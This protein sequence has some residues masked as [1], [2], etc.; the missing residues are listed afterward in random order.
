MHI[1]PADFLFAIFS[2]FFCLA[3]LAGMEQMFPDGVCMDSDLQNYTQILAA[4]LHPEAFS[5]DPLCPAYASYPGVPNLFIS[6]AQWLSY[7]GS[8][9]Y[10]IFRA[11]A[12]AV[13]LHLVLFYALGRRLFRS[14]GLS[15]LF[16]LCLSITFYWNFGT[17]WGATH[18]QA[19][20]RVLY[21]GFFYPLWLLLGILAFRRTWLRPL[22]LLCIGLSVQVHTV[23]SMTCAAMFLTAFL[24]T[25]QN[26][27][28]AKSLGNTA[29]CT[30]AFL[31]PALPLVFSHLGSMP[32]SLTAAEL[33]MVNQC[34][35]LM[36]ENDWT[37]PWSTLGQTLLHYSFPAAFLPLGL[38][39][40]CVTLRLKNRLSP[41]GQALLRLLPGF[42]LGI[43]GMLA[44]CFL[45]MRFVG[46]ADF[47]R[48][49][50]EL[51]RGTRFLI[52]LTWMSC[53]LFLACFW[54]KLPSLAR[55]SV[56]FL[57]AILIGCASQDA[58]WLAARHFAAEKMHA[59]FLDSA[60]A[61][62]LTEQSEN[63][64]SALLELMRRSEKDDLVYTDTSELAVRYAAMRPLV[65][66]YKDGWVV[67][68]ARDMR[69]IRPWLA[70]QQ[71]RTA[72]RDASAAR[73][74]DPENGGW[75]GFGRVGMPFDAAQAQISLKS[76]RS[77]NADWLLLHNSPETKKA[78]EGHI[79]YE[80]PDW[81]LAG[82]P[83]TSRYGQGHDLPV[84]GITGTK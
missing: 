83:H 17:F 39:L 57:A 65:P 72:A 78:L 13:F 82:Q 55:R 84:S 9:A 60:E 19:V 22:L 31:L 5:A 37:A 68:Y 61:V 18:S 8:A 53:F 64:R 16:S 51:F 11:G 59:P 74:A 43:A 71:A 75:S 14:A 29:L 30:A 15:A 49:S 47:G 40:W 62:R 27:S 54:E 12:L 35:A 4:W 3:A 7:D 6:L 56:P 24:V 34:W 38:A 70:E 20:P 77:W 44:M 58:Q 52:P 28:L 42:F 79:C 25:P 45:E 26:R 10:G 46:R 76:A 32:N 67:Y 50:L 48:V 66:T 41:E 21:A 36:A 2:A 63:F 73:N 23:S 69:L 81:L 80:N 1:R 33:D